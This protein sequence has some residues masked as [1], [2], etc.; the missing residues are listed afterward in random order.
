MP[1]GPLKDFATDAA[2]PLDG[3]RV[4]DLTR[5]VA[6]NQVSVLLADFGAEVIKIEPID[7]DPLRSWAPVTR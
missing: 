3:I 1:I 5:L 7:G 2:C 6:G 4:L